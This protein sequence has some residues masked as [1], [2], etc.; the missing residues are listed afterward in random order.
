MRNKT[1]RHGKPRFLARSRARLLLANLSLACLGA[2]GI[3]VGATA[4]SLAQPA[5][6]PP[7]HLTAEETQSLVKRV[8]Q[9]ELNAAQDS[10]HPMQYQLRKMS[11]RLA[12][13]KLI[14]ETKDGDVARLIAIND[15]PLS[16]QDQQIEE[17]RLQTL[18]HDPALQ[19]H[20]QER[21]QGDTERARKVMRALPDAF[22]Y[23]FAGVVD[24]QQGPSYRLSFQPNPNFDPQDL[25]AQVLKGM[26]GEMWI[27]VA[28]QR[29]TRLEGKRIRDVDY[30]WGILGK[31]DQGGTLL[32]QQADVGNHQWRT[33]HMV[34]VMNARVLLKTIK[35]DTTLEL[36]Q[37]SPVA[38][39]M[40]YQ[41]AIQILQSRDQPG[42]KSGSMANSSAPGP[43]K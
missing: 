25:E 8:L 28:E 20:R 17:T 4:T 13:T 29:V 16:P 3:A 43:G 21:E 41:Q 35:L 11:P 23:Q 22:H 32:L 38:A 37:F 30:G 34:L 7:M 24:T 26:A 18:F 42:P 9:T 40:S 5:E 39:G 1:G 6:P 19:R 12:T 33:T 36:S 15:G 31:L 27:D 2:L 14:V 10:N